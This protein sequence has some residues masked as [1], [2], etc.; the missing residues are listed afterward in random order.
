[1]MKKNL[2]PMS[3]ITVVMLLIGSCGKSSVEN[4]YTQQDKNIESLVNSLAPE[5]SE[6]TVDYF[7]GTVRVTVKH[8]DGEALDNGGTVSFYYAGHCVNSSSLNSSNL[9]VTNSKDFAKSSGWTVSD[10]TIFEVSTVNL[11]KD[12]LVKG[13][14]KGIVGVK[15]GD[16]CYI[17][18]NGKYGFGKHTN[19]KVPGNSA[20][21][22]HLW[23]TGVTNE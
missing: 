3:A 6:A 21:A 14:R 1:M 17:M 13:L 9:F 19:G 22:Y 5:G 7:D 20:L 15:S 11:A 2:I 4:A 8:G 18:F 12:D 10:S 23:I 16:E